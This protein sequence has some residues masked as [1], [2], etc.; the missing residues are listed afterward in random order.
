MTADQLAR[1]M[2]RRAA[3][4][5][6]EFRKSSNGL[7]ASAVKFCRELLTNEIYAFPVPTREQVNAER[8]HANAIKS[9]RLAKDTPF[10]FTP[11]A[12]KGSSGSK[13][14]WTRTGHLRRS[15]KAEPTDAYTVRVYN[16]A[17]Y[18]LPRHEMG[19]PGA[20]LKCRYPSHWRDELLKVFRP[21]VREVYELTIRKIL[22]GK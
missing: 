1:K 8:R 15:E 19:K 3:L 17:T 16:E 10:S 20:K 12:K 18:A 4:V 14:A 13:K 9:G 11:R 21:I 22:E 2:R 6:T 5:E 7:A